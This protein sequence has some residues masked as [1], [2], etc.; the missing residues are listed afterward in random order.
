[1]ARAAHE[2]AAVARWPL[3][4]AVLEG[5]RVRPINGS[6]LRARGQVCSLMGGGEA[7]LEGAAAR[8]QLK[9]RSGWL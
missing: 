9:L 7:G 3:G 5:A 6:E 2:F 4:G 1:M 8:E